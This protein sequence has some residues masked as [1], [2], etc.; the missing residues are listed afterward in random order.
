MESGSA[1]KT[2][3]RGAPGE[4][5]AHQESAKILVVD[6][7]APIFDVV[8]RVLGDAHKIT[9]FSD[10]ATAC[11]AVRG[12]ERFDVIVCD[13]LMP[14]MDGP[15]C[16]E[17]IR[18]LAPDQARRFVFVTGA[19]CL[20]EVRAFLETVSVPVLEKPFSSAALRA[21]VVGVLQGEGGRA[22]GGRAR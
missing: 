5:S 7:E 15:A 12:G 18:A 10:G 22:R 17:T 2:T 19:A 9:H 11:D 1:K 21:V 3:W 16:Y 8:V 20:P 14:G 4:S 6:N 13:V